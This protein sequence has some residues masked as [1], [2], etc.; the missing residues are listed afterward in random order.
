MEEKSVQTLVVDEQK[1]E[2]KEEGREV[3]IEGEYFD[4]ISWHLENGKYTFTGVF[5]EEETAVVG[6]LEKQQ[7]FWNSIIRLLL[8]GESFVALVYLLIQFSFVFNNSKNW[9]LFE[10][11]YKFLFNKIISPPPRFCS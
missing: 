10:N 11:R 4:L 2:W 8:L 9:S 1:V 6:L 5:D 3:T 7:V